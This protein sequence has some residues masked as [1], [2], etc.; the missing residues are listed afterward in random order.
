MKLLNSGR[1]KK[2]FLIVLLFSLGVTGLSIQLFAESSG[3]GNAGVLI[4]GTFRYVAEKIIPAVVEVDVVNIVTS[5]IPAFVS[6]F[7]YFFNTPNSEGIQEREYRSEGL[8]SGVIIRKTGKKVY[9]VTNN[10]VAGEAEEIRITLSDGREY[11]ASL[12]GNDPRRDV[13]LLLFE[14]SEEIPVAE[15]GDS[16]D[17]YVG[18]WTLAVGSPMGFDSTITAG[19][20]SAKGRR[21]DFDNTSLTDFIQTDASINRGNSGGALVNMSG[22]IIGINTWIAS[23]TGGNIGLGFAIPINS[24][25]QSINDIIRDGKVNYGWLGVSIANPSERFRKDMEIETEK[26][27][28]VFDTIKDS[29]AEKSGIL[30]GDHIIKLNGETIENSEHLQNLIAT[31]SPGSRTVFTVIRNGKEVTVHVTITARETG[32][33]NKVWPGIA[34]ISINDDIRESLNIPSRKG[35]V[36]I[37]NVQKGSPAETAGLR[38]GDVILEIN[39]KK[40]HSVQDFY[41]SINGRGNRDMMIR[42]YR[43]GSE[44]LIGL[45]R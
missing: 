2:I 22:E 4:P 36:V 23:S 13:A 24:I 44:V 15:L 43:R 11:E 12:I 18:D 1:R 41:T 45:I 25:K 38:N 7:D 32:G 31:I 30:P 28:F 5:R 29:P 9:V 34:V 8:G 6:P 42:I 40:V 37:G 33:E 27:S 16:D 39:D 14:T 19:I 26:G 10:H 17:I 3:S 20:I 35:D 21:Q